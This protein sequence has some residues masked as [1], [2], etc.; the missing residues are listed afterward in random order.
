LKTACLF[1]HPDPDSIGGRVQILPLHGA[2]P[3]YDEILRYAQ[4]QSCQLPSDPQRMKIGMLGA[5]R[6]EPFGFAQ[7][8]L[9]EP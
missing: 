9:V 8:R 4:N 2:C 7:D 1:C 3:E 6:G 5:V